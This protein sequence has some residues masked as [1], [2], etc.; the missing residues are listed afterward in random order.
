MSGLRVCRRFLLCCLLLLVAAPAFAR[1]AQETGFLNRSL[2]INGVAHKYQVYLPEG[3]NEHE[4]WPIILFLHGTGERGTEGMDETQIGLPA[5]IRMHPER[6]PFVVVMP[7]VPFNHHHWTD[8]DM[9]EMAMGALD[10]ETHEFHGDPERTYLTGLSLGGYGVWE[11]ARTY[12]HTFA[13][14]VPVSGGVF[15]SYQPQRWQQTELPMEY[16]RVVAHTPAWIFHGADDPVV[17]PKQSELMYEA[18]KAEGGNVRFWEYAGVRHNSWEKA[19]AV[20][21]LPHWFLSH[22]LGQDAQLAPAAERVLVPV[23]PV[24]AHVNPAVFDAY[25]GEYEDQGVTEVTI[26]RQGDSLYQ[27]TRQ[28]DVAELLPESANSFFFPSGST[29]RL[30]FERDSAGQVKGVRF[31]DD[32]HEDFWERKRN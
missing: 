27:R 7:Q 1:R 8:P 17:A 15:W 6:W 28:G 4:K 16:A 25:V 21:E 19:Y 5:A 29:S 10:L 26:Y 30:T 12:P 18:M 2:T 24:P 23:H 14:I 31:H 22:H 13:A 32:R 11:L 9:M 20:P 3:W